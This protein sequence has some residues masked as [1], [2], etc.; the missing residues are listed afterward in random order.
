MEK[1]KCIDGAKCTNLENKH[2]SKFIH[3]DYCD[4]DENQ[5]Y[6]CPNI[7]DS[8]LNSFRHPP[9]ISKFCMICKRNSVFYRVANDPFSLCVTCKLPNYTI[10]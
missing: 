10:I 8:H 3:P 4:F 9:R 2:N 5:G 1:Q 7:N 6:F